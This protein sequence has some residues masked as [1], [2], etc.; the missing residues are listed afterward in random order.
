MIGDFNYLSNCKKEDADHPIYAKD[1]KRV[2]NGSEA[3]FSEFIRVMCSSVKDGKGEM[4]DVP[5]L[6][7]RIEG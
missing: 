4:I 6:I 5:A 3:V 7:K 1:G 2:V